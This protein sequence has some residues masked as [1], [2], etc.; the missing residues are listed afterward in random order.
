MDTFYEGL[1]KSFKD[2]GLA[3]STLFIFLGDHG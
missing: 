1:I 2:K 3:N